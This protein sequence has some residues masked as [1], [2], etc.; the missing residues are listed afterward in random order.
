M[1]VRVAINGFGRM[2]RLALR[3]AWDWPE[4]E[5]AHVNEINGD[6]STA[7]HLL[8]F[9]SVHGRWSE[10]VQGNG[11]R[12]TVQGT[13]LGY[14]ATADPGDVPW[15]DLGIEVVSS[16]QAGFEPP[17]RWMPTSVEESAR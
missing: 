5:F 13:P 7:A 3:A 2:G 15:D 1:S 12:L 17:T 11:D 14:T 4:L 9:D 16:A 8:T 6:A 10:D